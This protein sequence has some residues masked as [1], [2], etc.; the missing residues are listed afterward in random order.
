MWTY[1]QSTGI[2]TAP[3]GSLAGQGYSGHGGGLNNPQAENEPD[4]GPIPQG[5]W[6]IGTFFDD[7]GGKG[8]IVAHVTPGPQTETYGRSG[9]MI[10]GD[11]SEGNHTASEGC[12]ILARPLRQAIAASGDTSL[13]VIA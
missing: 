6:D 1:Q 2:L 3:D 7:P 8:P 5:A 11:N 13:N 12:I 9:F 4:I 10:H